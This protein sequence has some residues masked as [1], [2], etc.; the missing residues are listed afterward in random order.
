[1]SRLLER[2]QQSREECPKCGWTAGPHAPNQHLRVDWLWDEG[3]L[4]VECPGCSYAW[5]E[6]GRDDIQPTGGEETLVSTPGGG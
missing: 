1:M 5:L 2:I 4:R 6:P 3:L